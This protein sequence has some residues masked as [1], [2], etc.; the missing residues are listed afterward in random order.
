MPSD[1]AAAELLVLGDWGYDDQTA[2]VQVAAGLSAYTRQHSLRPQ[3]LLML[4]DNWY[5]ELAG[6]AHSTRWQTQFEQMYPANDFPCPAYAV[7][8]NHDYQRWPESKVDAELEYARNGRNGSA[9]TR[10]TMPARW[11]RFEFPAG[12]PLVTFLALD[13]NM[14]RPDGKEKGGRDF[15]LT[16]EQQ[17]EQLA[18]LEAEL[19]RPRTTPFVA[20]MAHH[21]VFTNGP[22][23]DHPVLIRDWDPLFRKYHVDLY[24]AGHD[25]D[26][27]HLEFEGHPTSHF[28]SGSAGA[29]LYSLKIE[30]SQRGPYAQ[31]VYG[32]SHISVTVKQMT[33]RHLDQNGRTLHAFTKTPEGKISILG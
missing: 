32:F 21:P 5:G 31:K 26:L 13:S 4:G 22:H 17:A 18:W 28:L 1:R 30:P 3:A 19:K 10:W 29:D 15:T 11:Y 27:Q 23:G 12:N 24:M 7:L 14:P 33:L 6:G 25:H 16:A 2:Q 8:G 20:I 9:A